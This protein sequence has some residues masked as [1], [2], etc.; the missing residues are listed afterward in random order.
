[1][2][3][4]QASAAVLVSTAFM[5][6]LSAPARAIDLTVASLE[7][8]QGFQSGTTTLVGGRPTMVRMRITV[9]GSTTAV[10]GVDGA[11]RVF[12]AG[13]EVPGSPFRSVNGPIS[14][15]LTVS[16]ATIDH[17]L[18]F[19]FVPPTSTDVD[20]VALVNPDA[21]VAES[22]MANNTLAVSNKIFACRKTVDLCYMSI[23][24]TPG[25]GQPATSFT[26]PGRGDNFTRGIYSV[27]EWNYHRSPT[28]ILTWSTDV[29]ASSSSLLNTLSTTRLTTIP[30]LGY[31]RPEFMYGWVPGNPYSG[32]GVANGIPGD[33]AFGN[34]ETSRFQRTF[35]HELGHLWGRSHTTET[36]VTVATDVEH[37]LKDPLNL[38][39]THAASQYDV[40]VAGQLTNVAWVNAGT[41]NDCL[42]DAR[43]QC[44]AFD[45]GPA[46]SGDG[47]SD[48]IDAK[49]WA[50]ALGERCLRVCGTVT[51]QPLGVDLDPVTVL[52]AAPPTVDDPTGD[53]VVRAFD[54]AGRLLRSIRWRSGS[55]RES[56]AANGLLAKTPI[57][58]CIPA[59][60]S[61]RM[62]ASVEVTQMAN[63]RLLARRAASA[64]T[65]VVAASAVAAN[66]V[67]RV[68]WSAQDPDGDAITATV[69]WSPDGGNR[70][71]P[72]VVD[73]SGTEFVASLDQIPAPV[74]DGALVRVR[75][76][77]GFRT[78]DAEV[79]VDFHH[80]GLAGG[81]NNAPDVHLISPNA[82]QTVKQGGNLILHASGWDLEDELMA[83]TRLA[84]SSSIDGPLGTGRVLAIGSLSAGTHTL[85]LV[86]TDLGGLT[87][88]RTVTVTVQARSLVDA[89]FDGDGLVGGSDLS[90]L[91]ANWNQAGFAAGD[92][93]F[94]QTV[95]GTDL[96]LMLAHW[97]S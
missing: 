66:G 24:Y 55:A 11:L 92:L 3:P 49:A 10:A 68:N 79:A 70:W 95:D 36:L 6:A 35:A 96:A 28:P 52:D 94:N 72:L 71:V 25:G 91:L 80:D 87:T 22:N 20:F 12:S 73:S 31:A 97:S 86:G 65:P 1:M 41:I 7:I 62:V 5:L 60:I 56:C 69:C 57:F 15:P 9:T 83:P 67:V 32:N 16:M 46:D 74:A 19:V 89:D 61:R 39:Q 90:V 88:T 93:D 38:G 50:A 42:T 13:V 4:R 48:A 30:G 23:N 51:H 29:N 47:A 59:T 53:L 77:D 85:T 33:A 14:A 64:N 82:A 78:T 81:A 27:G 17:T 26:E 37:H 21:R 8:T 58:L 75:A 45:G 43:S 84:W 44:V 54:A 18:N 34:S 40:M 2:N 63:A 76:S